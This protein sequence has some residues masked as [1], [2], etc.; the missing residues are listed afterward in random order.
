MTLL[1]TT[2]S[3]QEALPV[4]RRRVYM[5]D[6]VD[7]VRWVGELQQPHIHDIYRSHFNDVDVHNKLSVG[8]LAMWDSTPCP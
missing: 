2:G 1:G 4:M 7:R 3:L 5:S 6:N 8:P